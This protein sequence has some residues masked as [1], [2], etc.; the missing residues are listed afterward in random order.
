M[1]YSL[2]SLAFAVGASA[3]VVPRSSCS[4]SLTATGG[5]SG[6]IGSLGDGQLRIGGGL[7]ATTFSITNNGTITDDAGRGCI[8]TPS[9]N[10]FQCDLNVAGTSGFSISSNSSLTSPAGSTTF[11]ACPA[12]DTEWNLY[13]AAV[14]NQ[15]KCV[16]IGLTASGCGAQATSSA[17]AVGGSS[18]AA[19]ATSSV[20]AVGTSSAP[21]EETVTVTVYNDCAATSAPGPSTF[22]T[23]VSPASSSVPAVIIPSAQSS[24]AASTA[25]VSETTTTSIA[26]VSTATPAAESSTT[27]E[28]VSSPSPAPSS[29]ESV[30]VIPTPEISSTAQESSS[31]PA[32]VASSSES[33]ASSVATYTSTLTSVSTESVAKSTVVVSTPQS[34]TVIAPTTAASSSVAPTSTVVVSSTAAVNGSSSTVQTSTV[35]PASSVTTTSSTS[36]ATDLSGNY[37]YPHLIIP[38]SSATPDTAAGTQ[39]FGT[40][41]SNTSTIFN[42]DIPSS[43]SGSTCSLIMLLPKHEDL[44]T[45]SYTSSGSGTIDFEQL[46]SV[47]T[48]ETTYNNQP[49]VSQDLGE[50]DITVGSSTVISTFSCPAG[51]AVAFELKAVG[52]TYLYFFEDWN[53]SPLG[54]FITEC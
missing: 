8:L 16:Q 34:T 45:S 23:S 50:F 49:S 44:E 11:Y 10:Q 38:V 4:F 2:V 22:E 5:E 30:V 15:Q 41:S 31:T 19:Q 37:Q 28:V 17:A 9:V 6:S 36:C 26:P 20:A 48:E 27:V 47:A 24:E 18:S 40:V 14:E 46:S 13:T 39:Y 1:Q 43:Y 33:S 7:D 32:A 3:V 35:T 52:D 21:A 25:V 12:S 42:F 54:L 29:T 53:P 51:E